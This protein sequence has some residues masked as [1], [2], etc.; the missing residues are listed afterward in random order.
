[1]VVRTDNIFTLAKG[2]NVTGHWEIGLLNW[3][4]GVDTSACILR[5]RASDKLTNFYFPEAQCI[6]K[7]NLTYFGALAREHHRSSLSFE[8]QSML[9]FTMSPSSE[10]EKC[11]WSL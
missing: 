11:Y 10:Y 4:F 5:V 8:C 7:Y 2:N 3:P 6:H 1:M 9:N